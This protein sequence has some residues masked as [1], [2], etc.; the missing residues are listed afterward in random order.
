MTSLERTLIDITARPE[1]GGGVLEILN[2]YKEARGK[3]SV[4]RLL[5][6]LKKFEYAYPYHQAIGFLMEKAGYEESLLKRL[7]KLEQHHDFYLDYQIKE[8]AYS[9]RWRLYYP[10]YLD[11]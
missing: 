3:V 7:E 11:E 5:A 8:R 10:K 9:N 1:Y 6:T 4:S 2:A